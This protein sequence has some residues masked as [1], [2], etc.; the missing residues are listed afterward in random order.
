MCFGGGGGKS[1]EQIYQERKPEFGALPSLSMDRSEQ[2]APKLEDV[3]RKG[4]RRR[5]L[6][7]MGGYNA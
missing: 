6:L 1:A 5:S 2:K 3:V 4:A 7:S